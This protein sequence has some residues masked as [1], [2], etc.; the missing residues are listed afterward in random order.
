MNTYKDALR[1]NP[2]RQKAMTY[3][4]GWI[5]AN[6][7]TKLTMDKINSSFIDKFVDMRFAMGHKPGSVRHDMLIFLGTVKLIKKFGIDIFTIEMPT[8]KVKNGRDRLLATDQE[9]RF[10]K[11][12]LPIKGTGA[13]DPGRSVTYAIS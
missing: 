13:T 12:L 5:E 6:M 8:V 7:N 10:L 2:D 9:I 3:T 11:E 1:S 4:I